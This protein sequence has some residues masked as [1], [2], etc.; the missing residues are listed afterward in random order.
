[1]NH[2][3]HLS[4]PSASSSAT[5][6]RV[7]AIVGITY[8]VSKTE[9]YIHCVLWHATISMYNALECHYILHMNRWDSTCTC[10]QMQ[11]PSL[12]CHEWTIWGCC[13]LIMQMSNSKHCAHA[14]MRTHTV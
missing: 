13:S 1:L 7:S 8:L 9:C 5:K 14:S 3:H 11:A 4:H 10:V 6:S 12:M 2:H